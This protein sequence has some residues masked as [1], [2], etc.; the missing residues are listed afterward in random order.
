MRDVKILINTIVN[1]I[2]LFEARPYED[3]YICPYC[4]KSRPAPEMR[5]V[6]ISTLPHKDNCLYMLAIKASV[7]V[8]KNECTNS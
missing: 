3:L 5:A 1:K 7:E 4:R 2:A 8:R 6:P